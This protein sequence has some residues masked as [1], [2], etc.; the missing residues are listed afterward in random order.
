MPILADVPLDTAEVYLIN[1]SNRK[2]IVDKEDYE[3]CKFYKWR[4]KQTGTGKRI[5]A[6]ING[7]LTSLAVYVMNYT[8]SFTIDHRDTDVFNNRKQN[9]READHY[10]QM[11]NRGPFKG[12]KFKGVYKTRSGNFQARIKSNGIE[13]ALGTFKTEEKAAKAYDRAAL[14][15]H[16][17]FAYLNF[18]QKETE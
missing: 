5:V 8:G 3:K 16:K 17:E 4:V 7:K 11:A 2:A 13:K 10:E 1:C 6:K 18:K 15:Y 14:K 12:R 9:L